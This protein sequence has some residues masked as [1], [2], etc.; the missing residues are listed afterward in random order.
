[1]S[2]SQYQHYA[3]QSYL[4]GWAIP[5]DGRVTETLWRY[6]KLVSKP[7]WP[8]STGGREGLYYV[9]MGPEDKRNFMEDVFW[10]DIDQWGADGLALLRD[11][12]PEAA[13]KVNRGR[14]AIFINSFAFRNPVA[15]HRLNQDAKRQVLSGCLSEDY[16]AHRRAH[17]PDCLE[18][19]KAQ[20]DQPFLCEMGAELL[21][22][23]VCHDGIIEQLLSMNWQVVSITNSQPLLTSDNPLICYGGMKDDDGAWIL[24]LSRDECFV[25]F[26]KSNVNMTRLI[27]DNIASGN[28]VRGVN[29]SVVAN[30]IDAVYGA[31]PSQMDF[32]ARHF[33]ISEAPYMPGLPLG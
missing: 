6:N 3:P 10:K 33:S 1:M 24:P 9:P 30:K 8:S 31:E 23:M 7:K 17:E 12:R 16:A 21:R 5:G 27:R 28:F 26:N 29:K 4:K 15:I 20:L 25:A 22:K 14:L 2:A 11:K 19:F 32:V 13:D 18:A